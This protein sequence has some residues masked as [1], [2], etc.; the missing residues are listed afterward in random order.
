MPAGCDE[1]DL[2]GYKGRIGI[3]EMLVVDEV[4]R[5]AIRGGQSGEELRGLVRRNGIRLMHEQVLD[6]VCAGSTTIEEVERVVP[7]EHVN[8]A[9]CPVCHRDVGGEFLFCP[10]C[11]A[12][13]R[14]NSEE[15]VAVYEMAERHVVNQ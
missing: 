6:Q 12:Q 9:R 1:C 4:I 13:T 5:A 14:A 15:N 7:I 2:T 8:M 11:G 10:Y 3:Y